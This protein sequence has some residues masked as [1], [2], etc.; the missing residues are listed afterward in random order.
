MRPASLVS[1][2]L[3]L[4]LLFA[5]AWATPPVILDNQ[6]V[7]NEDDSDDINQRLQGLTIL[8]T[9]PISLV[10][11]D[12]E[13]KESGMT[14]QKQVY[15]ELQLSKERQL[16]RK[17]E[18]LGDLT[19]ILHTTRLG[20]TSTDTTVTLAYEDG[21][22]RTLTPRPGGPRY[23]AKGDEFV[24]TGIGRS[25]VFWRGK[26]LVVETLLAPRGTMMETFNT[27]PDGAQLEVRT[28]LRNPDW[29]VNPE[30][31][32]VFDRAP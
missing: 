1:A 16:M 8:R 10:K 11:A 31:L 9:E 29:L 27:T 5:P 26:Q 4:P 23:S 25:M 14:R 17:V 15:D 18:D 6:W 21:F 32:R 24:E 19:R 13:R 7:L 28:V 2:L 30:I 22:T 20:V 3:L 12:R